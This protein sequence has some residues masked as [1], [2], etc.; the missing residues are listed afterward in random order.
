MLVVVWYRELGELISPS[1][2]YKFIYCT[3]VSIH[4]DAGKQAGRLIIHIMP[5]KKIGC[6]IQSTGSSLLSG[7][8]AFEGSQFASS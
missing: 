4:I 5:I 2:V 6:S 7:K 8:V 3:L 1:Q